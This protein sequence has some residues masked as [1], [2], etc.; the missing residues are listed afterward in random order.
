[1]VQR[2]VLTSILAASLALAPPPARATDPPVRPDLTSLDEVILKNGTLV[3]GTIVE[4]IPGTSVTISSAAD[5]KLLRFPADEVAAT[6]LASRVPEPPELFGQDDA[7]LLHVEVSGS[8]QVQ[9]HELLEPE[10][11]RWTGLEWGRQ[12]ER[13][14]Y[15]I[16]CR[17]PCE[18]AIDAR[19]GRRFFFASDEV[20][21][22][23]TFSLAGMGPDV[24][25]HVRPGSSQRMIGGMIAAPIGVAG[26]VLGTIFA[27]TS[28]ADDSRMTTPGSAIAGLGAMLIATGIVL[29]VTGR[30][31][32]RLVPG[33]AR[34]RVT[35]LP[36][37]TP[38]A[39]H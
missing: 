17:A 16:R 23:R 9:L 4:Y 7:P 19:H 10:D 31:R 28:D 35:K 25:A 32:V 22:S 21:R 12:V 38:A 26:V 13:V 14:R 5:G 8:A 30:T 15:R 3:R 18:L 24:R 2:C 29:L 39:F 27:A 33:A 1:M 6:T 37:Y 11:I 34:P 36:S 20:P